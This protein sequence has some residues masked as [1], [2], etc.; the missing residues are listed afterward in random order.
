MPPIKTLDDLKKLAEEA[1]ENHPLHEPEVPEEDPAPEPNPEVDPEVAAVQTAGDDP[2]PELEAEPV[3]D[4]HVDPAPEGDDVTP[5]TEDDVTPP[6]EDL[7][8]MDRKYTS[9]KQEYE[10]PEWAASGV[11]NEE[12]AKELKEVYVKAQGVDFL[13]EKN[14]KLVTERDSLKNDFESANSTLKYLD[15]LV[16]TKD[17]ENIQKMA[18]ISDDQVLERA[19][20]ILNL[21]ELTPEQQA[22]YNN[23]AAQRNKNY[24]AEVENANLRQ[25]VNEQSSQSHVGLLDQQLVKPDVSEISNFYDSKIGQAGS[26]RKRV[27]DTA[28]KVEWESQGKTVLTPEQAVEMVLKEVKPFYSPVQEPVATPA[29]AMTTPSQPAVDPRTKPTIPTMSGGSKSPAKKVFKSIQDLKDHA[30]TFED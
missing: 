1:E 3:D 30:A 9:L 15:H 21:K 22:A 20:Q 14:E 8:Q 24:F 2:A 27:I 28:A 12:Q 18:R 7:Y 29:Q 25:Q 4:V 26:F 5:P 23:Q 19:A 10:I 13:N 11:K 6:T 16:N 17:F